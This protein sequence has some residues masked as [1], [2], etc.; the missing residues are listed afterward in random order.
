MHGLSPILASPYI[1]GAFNSYKLW[2]CIFCA[3]LNLQ[4]TVLRFPLFCEKDEIANCYTCNIEKLFHGQIYLI[5][6]LVSTF[7]HEFVGSSDLLYAI[8]IYHVEYEAESN[9]KINLNEEWAKIRNTSDRDIDLSSCP[10][11]T[12]P[13]K[14][15]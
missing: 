11:S 1:F 14:V 9:C 6:L 3:N 13:K 12:A 2:V 4:I 8:I 15:N 7:F 5:L 10:A